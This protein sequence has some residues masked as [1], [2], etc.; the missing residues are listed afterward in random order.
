RLD[1]GMRRT[2]RAG[3][4]VLKPVDGPPGQHAWTCE[5]YAGWPADAGVRWPPAWTFHWRRR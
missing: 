2:W 3:D 4:L 5:V 1:G